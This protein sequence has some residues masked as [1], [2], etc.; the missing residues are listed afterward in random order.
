MTPAHR[1][2][3]HSMN[4][5]LSTGCKS[6]INY[7]LGYRLWLR[8][9]KAILAQKWLTSGPQNLGRLKRFKRSFDLIPTSLFTIKHTCTLLPY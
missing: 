6:F 5:V 3:I 8:Q 4:Q 1:N 7:A 2:P 9:G